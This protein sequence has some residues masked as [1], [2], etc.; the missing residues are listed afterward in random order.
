MLMATRKPLPSRRRTDIIKARIAG[1]K[2]YLRTGTYEDGRLGEFFVDMHKDGAAM[3]S[4]MN[5]FAIAMSIGLQHGVPL[6]E[7]VDAFSG[8]QFEPSGIVRG[9]TDIAE[10]TSVLD[11]IVRELA[12]AHPESLIDPQR[13]TREVAPC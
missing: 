1:H 9:D 2:V 8:F 13:L 12:K 6:D 3:R 11:W 10:C 7:Y 5:A 4:I